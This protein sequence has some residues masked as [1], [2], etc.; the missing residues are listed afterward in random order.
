MKCGQ[1]KFFTEA[2]TAKGFFSYRQSNIIGLDKVFIITGYPGTGKSAL[3][4]KIGDWA[5]ING[6]G[7]EMIHNVTDA[8]LLSGV[9]IPDRGTAVFDETDNLKIDCETNKEYVD[10][11]AAL[12]SKT[13]KELKEAGAAYFKKKKM[14]C[15]KAG[16]AFAEALSVHDEWEKI[17]I[18]NMNFSEAGNIANSLIKEIFK[19]DFLNKPSV[20]KHRFLGAPTPCGPVDFIPELTAGTEKRYLI[21]GRPGS[22]KSTMLKKIAYYASQ[23]GFDTEIYHCAFDPDSLDMLIFRELGI[24]IFD[25]TLPHEYF[26]ERKGDTVVDM[27]KLAIKEGTDEKYAK[28][29]EDLNARYK[30]SIKKGVD[31]LAKVQK[32]YHEVK[33][34]LSQNISLDYVDKKAEEIILIIQQ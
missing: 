28:R 2:Y 17:Y 13:A 19:D 22:G 7:V 23:K 34:G 14:L 9:I 15:E 33:N 25:S 21:K 10:L 18:D 32:A 12:N 4:K 16:K 31:Y 26:P 27:Y 24:S 11:N 30:S 5:V 29:I 3:I 6:L 1:V 8:D 20:Q